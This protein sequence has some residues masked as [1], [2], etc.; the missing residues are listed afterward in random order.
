MRIFIDADACPV[1]DEVYKVAARY[2]LKVLVLHRTGV[3]VD[4]DLEGL[5]QWGRP[6]GQAPSCRRMPF[7]DN[8]INPGREAR[9][10]C[11]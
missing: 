3:G 8:Q 5:G 11:I 9:D 7:R 2:N 4:V 6:A 1:K 10:L